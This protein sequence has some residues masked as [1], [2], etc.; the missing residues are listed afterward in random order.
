[1]KLTLQRLADEFLTEWVPFHERSEFKVRSSSLDVVVANIKLHGINGAADFSD[2]A[3]LVCEWMR[4][5]PLR[6]ADALRQRDVNVCFL[7]VLTSIALPFYGRPRS[8]PNTKK[9]VQ[10]FEDEFDIHH[11]I[12]KEVRVE[13]IHPLLQSLEVWLIE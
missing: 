3:V 9:F 8:E 10:R 13:S 5:E 2:I 6:H 12:G 4:C 7:G 1:M 11:P